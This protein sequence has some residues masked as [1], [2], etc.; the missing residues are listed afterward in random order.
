VADR[1]FNVVQLDAW[2]PIIVLQPGWQM[3]KPARRGNA[4][5]LG[6]GGNSKDILSP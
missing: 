5:G 6:P 4:R 3:I 2:F 1:G